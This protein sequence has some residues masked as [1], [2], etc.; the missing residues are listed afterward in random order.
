MGA[1]LDGDSRKARGSVYHAFVLSAW[2]SC[3]VLTESTFVF[4]SLRISNGLQREE[5][6]QGLPGTEASPGVWEFQS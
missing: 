4:W 3:R 1:G 5:L 2:G 6:F